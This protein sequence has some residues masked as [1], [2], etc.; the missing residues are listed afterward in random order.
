MQCSRLSFYPRPRFSRVAANR[1]S[2]ALRRPLQ[3]MRR[4]PLRALE[5]WREY[6]LVALIAV[7]LVVLS[8]AT[9]F[10][11]ALPVDETRYL[12]V[13]WEMRTTGSWVLPTLNFAPY[14]H[15]PP[16]LFWLINASWSI[17]G[18]S[19]WPA[20]LVGALAM[21]AVLASTHALDKRLAPGAGRGLAPGA[22]ML[23]GLPLFVTL[24]FAIMFDML[25]TATVSAA[26]L[27]LWSAGRRGGGAAFAAYG[28]CVSLGVLAKGPVAL[29][30]VLPP[31]LLARYWIDPVQRRGW[32]LRVGLALALGVGMA[33]A[34]ALWAAHLGGPE[35]ADMLLWKQS[36]GRIA[37]S[38][39]HARP[40]WFYV[41]IVLLYLAPLW[42]WRPVWAGFRQG[43]GGNRAAAAFLL[44]WIV[45]AFVGLSVISGKQLHY[46][47]PLVPGVALLVSL[48]LRQVQPGISDRVPFL[49][50]AGLALAALAA[51]ALAPSGWIESDSSLLAAAS[52]ISFPLLAF[53]GA[54]V[55]AVLAFTAGSLQRSLAG[56]A[57]ANLVFLSSVVF[58]TRTAIGDLFDLQPVADVIHGFRNRPIAVAQ[59][60]RGEF[61][62]LSRLKAPLVH[63]PEED[64]SCWLSSNP[65]GLAIVRKRSGAGGATFNS[66]ETTV[67][68]SR[69]YRSRE[70]V[71]LLARTST[72]IEPD[73]TGCAA[74]FLDGHR[75]NALRSAQPSADGILE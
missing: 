1:A 59:Q 8:V 58:Q 27:A 45:P 47:L 65:N 42:L 37:S 40:I 19:V 61:G 5:S 50:F 63:V 71:T 32:A 31:A 36:A 13:A 72:L 17:F 26:M 34:W 9:A 48:V 75:P 38:F 46:L 53:S 6:A 30:F 52:Q 2:H 15:K 54:C 18:V 23:L 70:T 4:K 28:I 16:L 73:Q 51:V 14:S 64:L 10:L 3:L 29:M 60:T 69:K 21:G 43:F 68:L 74:T 25:L 11:P 67:L 56:L 22:L 20:R 7:A 39:S 57:L 41:P 49:I 35:Y 62:F 66:N 33:L 55:L 24:G 12:T 44:C